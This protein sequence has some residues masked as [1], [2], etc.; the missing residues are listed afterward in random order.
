ML[1]L[2]PAEA[3]PAVDFSSAEIMCMTRDMSAAGP[4]CDVEPGPGPAEP[5]ASGVTA[6]FCGTVMDAL[7]TLALSLDSDANIP[8]HEMP[9]PPT[10]GAWRLHAWLRGPAAGRLAGAAMQMLASACCPSHSAGASSAWPLKSLAAVGTPPM[11]S[12]SACGT[13]TH[14]FK[15][16]RSL[17]KAAAVAAATGAH[18]RP[19][20][21]HPRMELTPDTW[22]SLESFLRSLRL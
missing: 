4:P 5:D 12:L 1:P 11:E 22:N 7:C 19:Q 10:P 13:G 3:A 18:M 20:S 14:S 21:V 15:Q 17:I 2:P 6:G 8:E 9:D 16:R